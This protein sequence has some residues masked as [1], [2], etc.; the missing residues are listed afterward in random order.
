MEEKKKKRFNI[1]ENRELILIGLIVALCVVVQIRNSAFLSPDNIMSMLK[2][3]SILIIASI[4]MMMVI[5]TGGI[6][7][8]IASVMGFTCLAN[9]FIMAKRFMGL[10][11]ILSFLIGA[12]IGIGF[13]FINGLII[14]KGKVLPIIATM[15]TMN[16]IRGLTVVMSKGEQITAIGMNDAYK[17]FATGSVLGINN[18][19]IFAAAVFVIF[20]IFLNLF[21]TGRQIYAVG[22]NA[23]SARIAGIRTDR[24]EILVYVLMGAI[25]G[26][27]GILW[28]SRYAFASSDSCMSFE[29]QVIPAV[30]L[31]G[32]SVAGGRGKIQGVL[33][34]AILFGIINN[35]LP[36]LLISNFWK[37]AIQGAIIL[38]A[39][40]I[41]V[42][43][44]RRSNEKS[45]KMR[46]I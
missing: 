10:P 33:L 28:G 13:G 1:A 29:M 21:R 34:G 2:D 9:A 24:I 26:I 20:F 36:M 32:V 16:I 42:L 31:G 19:I 11:L 7:L 12:G 17:N 14:A 3:T 39:I 27:C 46:R 22:S 8:S 15:G 45:L 5:L 18:L 6:D 38:A 44:I 41:N 23:E 30:V 40:I 43:L 4:G 37:Q 35:S 25:S